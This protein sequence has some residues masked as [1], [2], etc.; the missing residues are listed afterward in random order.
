M[1]PAG[2]LAVTKTQEVVFGRFGPRD[3]SKTY[4]ARCFFLTVLPRAKS[5]TVGEADLSGLDSLSDEQKEELLQLMARG[6]T[7][8]EQLQ[9][10]RMLAKAY[11]E[12]KA[13]KMEAWKQAPAAAEAQGLPA[14][15]KP[16]F[17]RKRQ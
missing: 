6:S 11:K 16:K 9:A 5:Y 8:Q 2:E 13:Q 10:A 15:A 12:D 1:I 7:L 3:V 14:P 17:P 4:H